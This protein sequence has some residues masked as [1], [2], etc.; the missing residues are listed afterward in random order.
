[1]RNRIRIAAVSVLAGS[2]LLLGA[3]LATAQPTAGAEGEPPNP[4]MGAEWQVSNPGSGPEWQVSNP[5]T[6]PEWQADNPGTGAEWQPGA[7]P[8]GTA[9]ILDGLLG[10]FFS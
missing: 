4:G 2:G 1:M 6:G 3:G 5:G 10:G 7:H 9:D 8:G